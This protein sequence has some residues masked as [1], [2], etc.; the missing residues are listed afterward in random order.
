MT[1]ITQ[2]SDSSGKP[3]E[4]LARGLEAALKKK[5]G[6]DRVMI[7]LNRAEAMDV[8]RMIDERNGDGDRT[9]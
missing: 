3:L 2:I 5:G 7:T 9:G 4:W 1:N 8:V 6:G